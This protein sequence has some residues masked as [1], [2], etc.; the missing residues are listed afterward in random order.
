ME[1][2]SF[3][4]R[5]KNV[6]EESHGQ[7]GFAATVDHKRIGVRYLATAFVFFLI[8]GLEALALRAQLARPQND[9][10][11]PEQYS[12]LFTMHGTTM[13]FLVVTP[14]LSGFGNYLIPL[15]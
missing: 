11:G 8:G 5:L 12:E 1:R 13:I 10:L 14:L 6:W 9:V 2:R 4:E 7:F 3:A 15:L